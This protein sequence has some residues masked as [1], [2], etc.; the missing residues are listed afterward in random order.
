MFMLIRHSVTFCVSAVYLLLNIAFW[1]CPIV[2]ASL[3]RL[4]LPMPFV[5]QSTRRFNNLMMRGWL[6]GNR[7]VFS[8]FNTVEWHVDDQTHLNP[9]GWYMLISNHISWLD[10]LV[11]GHLF[12][13]RIPVPKFFLKKELLYV[14]FLGLA[15]WGL[16]M[17]FMRRY[18]RAT[19]LK[20]PHLRGRDLET[21]QRSCRKFHTIPTTIINFVEGTRATPQ[22]L[23]SSQGQYKNLLNPKT[24][25][26]A[27]AFA[28][29]GSRFDRLIDVTLYYPENIH[30]PILDLFCGRLTRV[31]VIIV[32][33]SIPQ[34]F[35]QKNLNEV[36]DPAFK[37]QF[38]KWIF[39]IWREKDQHLDD[40]KRKI[41]SGKPQENHDHLHEQAL[42]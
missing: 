4:L 18:S 39:Q 29:L 12:G 10:T 35:R 14:P 8:L 22:K 19:L 25:G 3:V 27:Y 38:Q 11:L 2:I 24:G 23:Q 31:D 34:Q 6:F 40:M 30:S 33:R 15:C 16:D 13:Q 32:Q 9:Q 1:T 5:A 26:L 17:P 37:K 20:N 36:Q 42:S 28:A 21:A 7:V 41:S